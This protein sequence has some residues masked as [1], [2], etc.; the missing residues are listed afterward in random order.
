MIWSKQVLVT[1]GQFIQQHHHHQMSVVN[2]EAV[3]PN[4][5]HDSGASFDKPK[6]HPRTRVK[7][8]EI[9]MRW[10][11]GEDE[12]SGKRFMW[13]NGAA[14]CGKSAIAQSTVES[15]IEHGLPLASFFFNR[16]D[17]TRNHAGSL[18][19]TLA[20]QL[21][22][23]FP[24]TEVQ[25]EI[26]S[27]IKKDPLIF[28][29]TIQQQFTSLIIQPLMAHLSKDQSIPQRVPFLIV[30]DG[31]D[32]CI[33]RNA[34]KAILIGVAES[35]RNS[36]LCVPIFVASRPEHDIK[37]AFGSKF[38]KG[39]HTRLSLDLE[40]ED[41]AYSDIRLYLFDSFAEIKDDFDNRTMGRK[42]AQDWPGDQVI[43]TLV[44]RSSRQ[45]VYAATIIRFV[46][47]TRHRPDHRLDVVL[48]L[49]PV[50]GDH[51][52]AQLDELY[53]MIL[54]SALNT[55]KVLE[56]LSLCFMHAAPF[57]CSIMERLLSYD[58]G[59]VET[60]F[61]D[62]GA[63]VQFHKNDYHLLVED[64][65]EHGPLYLRLLH[66]SFQEY[67]LDVARSK[68]FHIDM[69]LKTIRHV[70][71]VLQYLASH[72]SSSFD[73]RSVAG[74]P[75]GILG[76]PKFPMIMMGH[77]PMDILGRSKSRKEPE[78]T[79]QIAILLELQQAMLSFPLKEF[80]E[81]H[82]TSI[83]SYTKLLEDFV[84]PYLEL[85]EAMVINY[86]TSSYIQDHQLGI[87]GSVLMQQVEQYF[88]DDELACV[89]VLFYHL[90]SHQCVPIPDR[91]INLYSDDGVSFFYHL[92]PFYYQDDILSLSRVWGHFERL[93]LVETVY[94]RLLRQ[95]LRDRGGVAKYALGARAA[96]VCFT[97]LART[98]LLPPSSSGK[99]LDIAHAKDDAGD[100]VPIQDGGEEI[101]DKLNG[102]LRLNGGQWRFE[103]ENMDLEVEE[104]YF[105]LLGYLIFLL[106]LCGRSD[107]LIAA[108]E[109]YIRPL[110][111]TFQSDS[112]FPRE[113][114]FLQYDHF[115]VRRRLLHEEIHKYLA[116]VSPNITHL[117]LSVCIRWM[118]G[119]EAQLP[120]RWASATSATVPASTVASHVASTSIS[121]SP[122]N[123]TSSAHANSAST[124]SAASA[125]ITTTASTVASAISPSSPLIKWQGLIDFK[126]GRQTIVSLPMSFHILTM[127]PHSAMISSNQGVFI[128][129]GQFNQYNNSYHGQASLGIKAPID[130][131]MEAVATSALHDSGATFDKP[132]CH[133]RTR[134][135]IREIIMNWIVGEDE[136][137]RAGKRFMWLTGAAG[138]GKSAIAQ[139]TVESCIEQG[140][141]LASFFFN[142]SDPTRNHEGS[143]IATLAYQLYCAFAE[144][145]VQ[146]EILSAI[147]KDPLIFKKTVQQQ[148]TA[149]IIRPLMTHLSKS[150]SIPQPVPFLIVIDSLDECI[151]RNAQKAILT[152]LAD[153]VRDSDLLIFVASRPEH[154][155][156]LSF[157]S[158]SLK[159]IHNRL[160]LDLEDEDDA[161]SDIKLYLIDRFAEIKDDFDNRT[162]GR[163][164]SQDWPGDWVINEL[165]SK[166]SRQ[167]IYAATVVRY[168]ESTRHRPD[169]RLDVVL[170]LRP[171]NGDHPFTELD[172]LY[173]MILESASDIERILHVLSLLLIGV[174]RICCSVIE[175]LLS[176]D[177]GEVE[178]LFS[179]LGALVQ[180]HKDGDQLYLRFL[181]ASFREYLVDAARSKQFYI[182]TDYEIIR[183]VTN[184]LQYLASCCSSSFN[185]SSI[186]ATP[187]HI[188]RDILYWMNLRIGQITISL[189][190]QQAVLFFPLKEFLEPYTSTHTYPQLLEHF[191]NTYLEL[192][193]TIVL[194]DPTLSYI[195]DHQ[196][197]I[198][199][200]I[201]VQQIQR[202]FNDDRLAAILVLFYHLGSHPFI[203]ILDSS[204]RN[205][206]P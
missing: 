128:T 149:L 57:R 42:L 76:R 134:V 167:F 3:A 34:Q 98:V 93:P 124:T 60:L 131:L 65:P 160:S 180:V 23:T 151:N 203:P 144:T 24:G 21:Y 30:I 163:K 16:S 116:R 156:K 202:Y 146:M 192:L 111:H 31:L 1:G 84:T 85:L 8:R 157:G 198:L 130:I 80:L 153:S 178:R 26:L 113:G 33:D 50:N 86:P 119:R 199:R 148:F 61:C 4:A 36:N 39:I 140:L 120:W 13:L 77:N 15:C 14:G 92:V 122:S 88:D 109:K 108:C 200:S 188:L 129:G 161:D 97:E 105:L 94:H 205:P 47:S 104:L 35:F 182:N 64:Y 58:E 10:I 9:I 7:I 38:L 195:K 75:M 169:H 74:T 110:E 171:D 95:L 164:L 29:K 78:R 49:R 107:A 168:V 165:V 143:L 69:E 121:A 89:L 17:S 45:F 196:L 136:E 90:G 172:A 22:C 63:L 55:E 138:C 170:N 59:E 100:D 181:H 51:P 187:M 114:S 197:D 11:L 5:L 41:N 139:S 159:D 112:P 206:S 123:S 19:A 54:E 67:L 142:R 62:M 174:P 201:L 32:E 126:V 155:I 91:Q 177:E 162:T 25:T 99:N 189:E 102:R 53:A 101:E 44:W 190:L 79:G 194:T 12:E 115:P 150:Q 179:D 27:A 166:S 176:C 154:D 37:L 183:H 70:I 186:A 66:A 81:P 2:K 133:P 52:F 46:Q 72:C 127:L 40:D 191:V 82:S 173:S 117:F 6:C 18:I 132:K 141:L 71:H 103:H 125:S 135:K 106:P 193:E 83:R 184:V 68:Q 48:K 158:K 147:Q 28:K 152:G 145:E 185:P 87:L 73:P 118:P 56:V 43:E 137:A 96:T 20:Y 204:S 175:K